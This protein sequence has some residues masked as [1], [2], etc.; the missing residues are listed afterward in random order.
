VA[1]PA[2]RDLLKAAVCGWELTSHSIP[3]G[4]ELQLHASKSKQLTATGGKNQ[5]SRL[6]QACL[7]AVEDLQVFD[8]AVLVVEVK[9]KYKFVDFDHLSCEVLVVT[10]VR[11]IYRFRLRVRIEDSRYLLPMALQPIY[12]PCPPLY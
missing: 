4:K 3:T 6:F 10:N 2:A 11:G 1:R 5:V 12:E 8:D 9:S 7:L